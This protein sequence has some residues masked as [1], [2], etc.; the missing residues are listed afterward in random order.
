MG[1]GDRGVGGQ[2]LLPGLGDTK[3]E[4]REGDAVLT[5]E[6]EGQGGNSQ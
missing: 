1:A 5:P 2:W 4:T 6:G 3:G